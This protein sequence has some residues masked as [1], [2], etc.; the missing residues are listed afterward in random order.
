LVIVVVDPRVAITPMKTPSQAAA[1]AVGAMDDGE[2]GI[3]G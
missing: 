1:V 3:L 2:G